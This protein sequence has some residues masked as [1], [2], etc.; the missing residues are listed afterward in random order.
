MRPVRRLLR[1]S[2]GF[3][4]GI[5]TFQNWS[6]KCRVGFRTCL[7]QELRLHTDSSSSLTLSAW[8]QAFSSQC[9]RRKA[10]CVLEAL[11][12]HQLQCHQPELNMLSRPVLAVGV[13]TQSTGGKRGQAIAPQIRVLLLVGS[14]QGSYHPHELARCPEM[15]RE[16]QG[17]LLHTHLGGSRSLA[18]PSVWTVNRCKMSP[19]LHVPC[20]VTT[21]Q[22]V[23][24]PSLSPGLALASRM[25]QKQ[26]CASLE[27]GP[28]VA[29]ELPLVLLESCPPRCEH[30]LGGLLG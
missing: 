29:L 10:S 1:S 21:H 12:K 19:C 8:R 4:R 2:K 25:Q 24:P 6:F 17:L 9:F 23:E 30:T 27:P 16:L 7:I 3:T 15:P 20:L 22:E 5:I 18:N 14:P 26:L 11:G 28:P 13:G